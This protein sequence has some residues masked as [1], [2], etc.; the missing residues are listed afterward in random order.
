MDNTLLDPLYSSYPTQPH[1]LIAK[2]WD[3]LVHEVLKVNS[4]ENIQVAL[5]QHSR[6]SRSHLLV[7]MKTFIVG[8]HVSGQQFSI[9]FVAINCVI[10]NKSTTQNANDVL[11]WIFQ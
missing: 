4:L 1:S 8:V 7:Y 2:L 6:L 3:F 5:P 10:T 9:L 11:A